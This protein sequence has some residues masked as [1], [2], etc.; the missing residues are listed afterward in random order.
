MDPTAAGDKD[1]SPASKTSTSTTLT[2]PAAPTNGA[3]PWPPWP[4]INDVVNGDVHDANWLLLVTCWCPSCDQCHPGSDDPFN[5]FTIATARGPPGS[6]TFSSL[7][8]RHSLFSVFSLLIANFTFFPFVTF[9]FFF[10]FFFSV[11]GAMDAIGWWIRLRGWKKSGWNGGD[12]GPTVCDWRRA[13][14]D[15]AAAKWSRENA[16][17]FPFLA[18]G[19]LS[20]SL[21]VCLFFFF[22]LSFAFSLLFLFFLLFLLCL[23]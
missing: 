8:H 21:S 14:T 4:P 19:S 17:P 22:L 13:T 5:G 18:V 9:T 7:R 11:N 10:C 1:T 3:A 15:V 6:L 2:A 20:L 16:K 23:L 12:S